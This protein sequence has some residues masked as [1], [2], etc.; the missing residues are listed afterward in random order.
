MERK[1]TTLPMVF[2]KKK[3]ISCVHVCEYTGAGD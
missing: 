1:G 3:V 2:L